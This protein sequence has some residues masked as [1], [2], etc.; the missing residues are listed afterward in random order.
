MLAATHDWSAD[1]CRLPE[2]LNNDSSRA[3]APAANAREF[4]VGRWTITV[5]ECGDH[6]LR[7]AIA[8]LADPA[9]PVHCSVATL[10]DQ[11]P[12]Q[13]IFNLVC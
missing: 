9:N 7:L 6:M 2:P 12:N 5:T 1:H 8:S 3:P 13:Q 10:P 11:V 4:V